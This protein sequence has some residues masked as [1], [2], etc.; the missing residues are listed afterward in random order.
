MM[1]LL[2]LAVTSVSVA[3]LD[4]HTNA[5]VTTTS[6][7][8]QAVPQTQ[9]PDFSTASGYISFSGL[10]TADASLSLSAV[11]SI[12]DLTN[13]ITITPNVTGSMYLEYNL[14]QGVTMY[15]NSVLISVLIVTLTLSGTAFAG[16]GS[17]SVS[18]A[19]SVTAGQPLYLSFV[20]DASSSSNGYVNLAFTP[21]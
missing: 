1:L 17:L 9:G 3:E 10:G 14:P 15:L 4:V 6:T 13:I 16:T 12:I 11:A 20:M 7:M 5:A 2:L 18:N 19:I 8:P 21:D